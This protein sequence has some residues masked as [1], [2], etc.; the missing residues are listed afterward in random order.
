MN[1]LSTILDPCRDFPWIISS[2]ESGTSLVASI[3][4]FQTEQRFISVL[5]F[6]LI[7]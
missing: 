6:P 3:W 1:Y 7:L 2:H 5:L 4:M